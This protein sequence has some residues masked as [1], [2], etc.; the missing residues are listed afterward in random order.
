MITLAEQLAAV[1]RELAIR[2]AYYP[3][4]VKAGKMT[5]SAAD[6]EISCM[7]A[8]YRTLVDLKAT[9]VALADARDAMQSLFEAVGLEEQYRVHGL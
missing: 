1:E 2:R 9:A 7:E 8:V 3:H 4:R 5:Q 6:E